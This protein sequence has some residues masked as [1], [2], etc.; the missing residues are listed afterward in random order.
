MLLALRQEELDGIRNTKN[1]LFSSSV[2]PASSTRRG[3]RNF[4]R[5]NFSRF[6]SAAFQMINRVCRWHCF[7]QFY[8]S[9]VV[10]DHCLKHHSRVFFYLVLSTS[11]LRLLSY[12]RTWIVAL[13]KVN[14]SCKI[15]KLREA[16][17][18]CAVNRKELSTTVKKAGNT[19][20]HKDS[21]A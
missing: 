15:S 21:L 11:C 4:M 19:S 17:S 5:T 12:L 13:H 1:H 16:I 7:Q 9:P 18:N 8:G 2:F 10:F 3:Q 6:S 20:K 14:R